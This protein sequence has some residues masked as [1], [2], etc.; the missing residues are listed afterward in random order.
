[1]TLNN[2]KMITETRSYI[3]RW[4]SHFRRSRACLSSLLSLGNLRSYDGCCNE[5]VT[6]KWN[7][8]GLSGLRLF[9][10]AQ[11]RRSALSLAWHEWFSCKGKE[12]KFYCCRLTLSPESQKLKFHVV[13]WQTTSK[14][15]PKSVTHVQ[16]DY[17][18]LMQ[19]IESFICGVVVAVAVVIS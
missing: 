10:V 9:Y 18:S 19:P 12:W 16:H 11:N 14:I 4:R 6:V 15:A 5:N 1:M 7:L 3:F 13:I 8:V 17:F 2:W